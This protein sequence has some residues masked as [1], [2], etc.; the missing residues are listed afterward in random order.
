MSN[1]CS[2]VP[3]ITIAR[4]RELSDSISK[5]KRSESIFDRDS[6]SFVLGLPIQ[7][8]EALCCCPVS[9]LLIHLHNLPVLGFPMHTKFLNHSN[10]KFFVFRRYNTRRLFSVLYRSSFTTARP[11][12]PRSSCCHALAKQKDNIAAYISSLTLFDSQGIMRAY[13]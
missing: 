5:C 1:K 7:N 8:T 12:L 3:S 6:L 13:Y 4:E 2:H 9:G 10:L 11:S